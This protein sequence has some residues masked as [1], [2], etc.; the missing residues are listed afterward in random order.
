M[1]SDKSFLISMDWHG[2]QV[3][4]L[5]DCKNLRSV[6]KFSEELKNGKLFEKN[7]CKTYYINMG[8]K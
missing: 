2:I 4:I 3:S 7:V 6:F 8:L 1:W 5:K